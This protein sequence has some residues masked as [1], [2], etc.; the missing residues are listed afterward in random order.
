MKKVLWGSNW[1]LL[2]VDSKECSVRVSLEREPRDVWWGVYW[3]KEA[4]ALHSVC[5]VYLCIVPMLPIH[6]QFLRNRW[7]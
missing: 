1:H 5:H 2:S 4:R 7:R 6:L 3:D